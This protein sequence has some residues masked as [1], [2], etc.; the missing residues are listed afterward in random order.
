MLNQWPRYLSAETRRQSS[1]SKHVPVKVPVVDA[2]SKTFKQCAKLF[3]FV[4]KLTKLSLNSI[5]QFQS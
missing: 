4:Y 3:F 5:S 1:V 2:R